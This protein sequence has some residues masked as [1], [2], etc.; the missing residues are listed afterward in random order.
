MAVYLG[1]FRAQVSGGAASMV[2][3]AA[4]NQ[5]RTVFT[6]AALQVITRLGIEGLTVRELW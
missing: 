5:R 6:N 4:H 3:Q 2:R 1:H